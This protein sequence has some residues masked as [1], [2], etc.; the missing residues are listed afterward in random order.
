M[1]CKIF[2]K[3][4]TDLDAAAEILSWFE[5]INQPPF[6]DQQIWWQ[7]QTILIEGFI[8]IVEH[9]HKNLSPLTPI[10]LEAIRFNKHIEIRIWCFGQPF[11]LA[12]QLQDT[13]ELEDNDKERGRGLKIISAIADKL[14]YEQIADNRYCLFMSKSY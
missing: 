3:V 10:E 4:N 12:Q 9:G 8:N 11:D 13:P 5:Q 2:L 14:T 1:E 6:P 7:L